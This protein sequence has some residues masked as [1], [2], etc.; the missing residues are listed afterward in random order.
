MSGPEQRRATY[1]DV[2]DAPEHVIAEVIDGELWLSPLPGLPQTSV[3]TNLG[4]EL[5]PPFRRGRGGPG[6][7]ITL[8]RPELH[9]GDEI[10]V[11][12]LAGWRRERLPVIEDVAYFTIAPDWLCEVLS[13]ATEKLDR[14]KKL[15]IYAAHGVRNVWIV[16]P[17][18]QT[19]E[20]LRLH[21][22]SW[23]TVAV[24]CDDAKVRAEP[25]DAILLDLAELWADLEI[26]MEQEGS[27]SREWLDYVRKEAEDGFAELDRGEGIVRTPAEHM[28][29]IDAVV[30]ARAA[31]RTRK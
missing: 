9:L 24:H 10:V 1:Q 5:G 26:P 2:L 14:A 4:G 19:L 12:D 28:A 29:Q 31:Q 25:F 11:P 3:A 13:D 16:N 27:P 6:G 20:V 18:Q 17:L 7:W 8:D 15:P 23:L 30:R 21:A 22:G